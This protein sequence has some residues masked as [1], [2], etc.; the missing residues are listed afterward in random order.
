[1]SANSMQLGYE[2]QYICT[3]VRVPC[4]I[5]IGAYNPLV[6][7]YDAMKI[8]GHNRV[9]VPKY[10]RFWR[11]RKNHPCWLSLNRYSTPLPPVER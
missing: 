3:L 8:S 6:P 9:K 7:Y 5:K 1:M 10:G 11:G 4:R 2:L